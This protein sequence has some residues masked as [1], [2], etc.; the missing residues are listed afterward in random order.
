MSAL[1]I[2]SLCFKDKANEEKQNMYLPLDIPV[3]Y[4]PF[5]H[6]ARLWDIQANLSLNFVGF[7]FC[8]KCP[9]LPKLTR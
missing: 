5:P 3:V 7:Y 8:S 1:Y 6:V 9:L 4:S 2:P